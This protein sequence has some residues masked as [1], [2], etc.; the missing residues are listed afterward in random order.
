[1]NE[2][3]DQHGAHSPASP[4][5]SRQAGHSRGS[6]TSTAKPIVARS[7]DAARAK[8][9]TRPSVAAVMG[10]NA[11]GPLEASQAARYFAAAADASG[12]AG[13]S[14]AASNDTPSLLWVRHFT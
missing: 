10:W 4:T 8:A 12:S 2:S 5:G 11:S 7:A 6:A 13:C 9:E 14:T 3:F 1:M